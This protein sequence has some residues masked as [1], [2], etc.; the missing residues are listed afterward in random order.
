MRKIVYKY[1]IAM[2]TVLL[3][4]QGPGHPSYMSK[5][6]YLIEEFIWTPEGL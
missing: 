6:H 1:T 5:K 4:M 3:F 2:T